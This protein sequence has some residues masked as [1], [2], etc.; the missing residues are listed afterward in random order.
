MASMDYRQQIPCCDTEHGPLIPVNLVALLHGCSESLGLHFLQSRQVH[1]AVVTHSVNP[2]ILI[3][4][5]EYVLS[6]SDI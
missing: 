4:T 5:Y 2:V 3:F 1:P 6:G